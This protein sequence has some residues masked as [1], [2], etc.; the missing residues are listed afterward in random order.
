MD[1]NGGL[2]MDFVDKVEILATEG[3]LTRADIK[4]W[5]KIYTAVADMDYEPCGLTP[6]SAKE[7]YVQG[8]ISRVMFDKEIDLWLNK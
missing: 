6:E 8:L 4:I 7:S 1:F 3:K 5:R 2:T